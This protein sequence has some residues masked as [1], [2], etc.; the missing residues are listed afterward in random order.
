MET[1][2]LVVNILKVALGLGFVIFLHE[3]GHFLLAKW[4]GVKVEKFSIGFGPTLLGF[5]RGET[6]YVLAAIP[7]GGFVKMLGEGP[8]EEASKSS[9]PRAFPNKSVGARMSIIVA[10]VIMNL[11]LGLACFVY[12]Y[13]MGMDEIAPTV[14]SVMS[15]APAYRA[16]MRPGDE[17]ISVDGRANMNFPKVTL[18]IRVSGQGQALHFLIKR[19]GQDAPIPIDVEPRREATADVPGIGIYP[20]SSL[21]LS[22]DP[23]EA[24]AGLVDPPKDKHA[25]LKPR[26]RV[27]A[28]GPVGATPE[29]VKDYQDYLRRITKYRAEPLQVLAERDVQPTDGGS[30]KVENVSTVFPAN[31]FVDFGFRLK[32]EAIAGI[33]EGSIADKAGFRKGD[34]I[35]SVDGNKAFDPMQLPTYCFEKA[36][37]P[38]TFEVERPDPAG[39][40][41]K[42]LTLT[43]TPDDSMPWVEVPFSKEPLDI[44][45]LGLAYGVRTKVEAVE[46]GSPA[47]KAGIK[48]GD[49]IN[50][51]TFEKTLKKW[52][53][54]RW[55]LSLVFKNTPEPSTTF[56]DK[57]PNWPYAFQAIQLR[58]REP[59]SF[60]VN[61]ADALVTITPEPVKS[62]PH[63]VRGELFQHLIRR[64]PPMSIAD[65]ARRG[66][67]DTVDSIL[68]IY[69]TFRSLAQR[70]V[71]PKSLGGP[72]LISQ[73]AYE[74]AVMSLTDLVHFLGLLSINLAVLN[75]LPIP[76]LDGG[77]MVFL[78]AEKVRGRPLP[79]SALAA[80]TWMGVVMVIMLMV[81]VFYQDV[82]RILI[83]WF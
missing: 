53:P 67:D 30:S 80:G 61:N 26:D 45:G 34:T 54:W 4:N 36:G 68:S 38:L 74:A 25:G 56:D 66:T 62:W 12:A 72:I 75:F 22:D 13:E 32:T 28:V 39:G 1:V 7:L 40:A 23:Y 27:V 81:F 41:T 43:A 42:T 24:P 5:T 73:V 60:R 21:T 57:S 64:T 77:Q 48:P 46:P 18:R 59:V 44:P 78:V 33:R 79:E 6:E 8:D 37:A 65:A 69:A 50:A 83:N 49:V 29:P 3:L 11:A 35:V 76:P 31:T 63:P 16:G 14:G 55:P 70:R 10:G 71:S 20:G 9:D 82:S 47:A 17:I 52:K 58:P 51:M 19:P 2:S 15:G